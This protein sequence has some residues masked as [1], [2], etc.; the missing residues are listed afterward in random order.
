MTEN[1]VRL[2]G[3]QYDYK[4]PYDGINALFLL[5]KP[6]QQRYAFVISLDKPIRQGQ[7]KYQHLVWEI[8]K[9][10]VDI[11][12]NIS[13]EDCSQKYEG[14]LTKQMSGPMMNMIAKIFKI[15]TRNPVRLVY[16]I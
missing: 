9:L 7:Q 6:D 5:P 11:E 8:H 3:A 12:L 4:I 15:L 16:I 1:F 13:E 10:N 14:Q 2:R